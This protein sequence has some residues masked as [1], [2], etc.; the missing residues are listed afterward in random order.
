MSLD[1]ADHADVNRQ[2]LMIYLGEVSESTRRTER[3]HGFIHEAEL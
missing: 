3:D 1:A 2:A